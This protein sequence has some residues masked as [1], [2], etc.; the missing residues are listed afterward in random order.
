MTPTARRPRA[1]QVRPAVPFAPAR[2]QVHTHTHIRTHTHTRTSPQ[3]ALTLVVPVLEK[4]ATACFAVARRLRAC[5]PTSVLFA[6]Q[7]NRRRCRRRLGPP[8]PGLRSRL[9]HGSPRLRPPPLPGARLHARSASTSCSAA[10]RARAPC[11]PPRRGHAPEERSTSARQHQWPGCDS[12]S[13]SR[14]QR[15]PTRCPAHRRPPPPRQQHSRLG[16]PQEARPVARPVCGTGVAL[17][18]RDPARRTAPCAR[19]ATGQ[20]YSSVHRR[21]RRWTRWCGD[22]S[23]LSPRGTPNMTT[24]S[25]S[26]APA[27]RRP[28]RHR[29]IGTGGAR[30][31]LRPRPLVHRLARRVQPSV[32]RHR[33]SVRPSHRGQPLTS[34]ATDSSLVQ[35]SQ[36]HA[37]HSRPRL[38][39]SRVTSQDEWRREIGP[40][41]Q[42]RPPPQRADGVANQRRHPCETGKRA[43]KLRSRQPL[44]R[45]WNRTA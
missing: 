24:R 20:E 13:T 45:R 39:K 9:P 41:T 42:T 44:G 21:S 8:P 3:A 11:P 28:R 36:S 29:L 2:S 17:T 14:G 38:P 15:L 32:L 26:R 18:V 7:T 4:T 16:R 12:T 5:L 35:H 23:S 34:T 43:V 30:R 6:H 40:Q 37:L 22:I 19:L 27:R 1:P 25:E 10:T 31:R 33:P